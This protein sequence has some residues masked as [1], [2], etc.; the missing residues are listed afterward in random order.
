MYRHSATR[1]R[2]VPAK[3]TLVLAAM[4][5][6]LSFG[7]AFASPTTSTFQVQVTVQASCTIVSSP[8][9]DFGTQGAFTA[10]VDQAS[11]IQVQCTNTTPYD[12]GLNAGTGSGAT[13]AVRKMTSGGAT[14]N[15]SLY[16]NN[17]RT[18]VWGNT[19]GTN[20]VS[21]TGSGNAQNVTVFGRVPSQTTPAPATYTDTIVATVTY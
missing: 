18:T 9:V 5:A 11:I 3:T 10:N 1:A 8:T 6:M 16:T 21:S 4:F 7:A 14:V 17:A 2:P 13:V 20:T 19:I 15:Y 12:I